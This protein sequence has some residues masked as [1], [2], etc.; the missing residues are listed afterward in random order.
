VVDPSGR[1]DFTASLPAD[2]IRARSHSVD[3]GDDNYQAV[4]LQEVIRGVRDAVPHVTSRA[5]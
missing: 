5:A 3:I 4:T 1:T 2:T